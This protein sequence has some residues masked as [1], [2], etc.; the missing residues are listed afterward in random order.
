VGGVE[1]GVVKEVWRRRKNVL[2]VFLRGEKR[3]IAR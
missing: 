1:K 3:R 2:R